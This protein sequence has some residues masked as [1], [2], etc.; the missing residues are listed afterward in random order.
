MT[1]VSSIFINRLFHNGENPLTYIL[2]LKPITKH[3][4]Y[5]KMTKVPSITTACCLQQLMMVEQCAST[6]NLTGALMCS[7]DPIW[8]NDSICY[9]YWGRADQGLEKVMKETSPLKI[10]NSSSHTIYYILFLNIHLLT[11]FL[12][13]INTFLVYTT[14]WTLRYLKIVK[15]FN[16]CTD[17]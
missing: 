8:H 3:F 2:V 5:F 14:S 17:L 12:K 11:T 9:R 4:I 6:A 13:V 15:N 7:P 1:T 10:I 16:Q